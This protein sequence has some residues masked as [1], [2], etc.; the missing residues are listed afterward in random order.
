MEEEKQE[1]R[2]AQDE[3]LVKESAEF[4]DIR[5][6]QS[7]LSAIVKKYTLDIDGVLRFQ[8]QSLM[9]GMLDILSKRSSDRSIVI[10]QNDNGAVITVTVIIRFGVSIPVVAK[11]IQSTIK[12]QIEELTGYTVSKVN[13]NVCDLEMPVEKPQEDEAAAA[14]DAATAMPIVPG[15]N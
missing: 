3:L 5:I 15:M 6:S 7:V 14:A 11:E 8:S 10:E 13:V 12:T 1:V 9:D 4:G 2:F